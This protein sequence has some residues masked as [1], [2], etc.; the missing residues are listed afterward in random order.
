MMKLDLD[1]LGAKTLLTD[2]RRSPDGALFS[3]PQLS[4]IDNLCITTDLTQWIYHNQRLFMSVFIVLQSPP[5]K[6]RIPSGDVGARAQWEFWTEVQGPSVGV[7][8]QF[9]NLPGAGLWSLLTANT[10]PITYLNKMYTVCNTVTLSQKQKTNNTHTQKNNLSAVI[11]VCFKGQ[12]EYLENQWCK[13]W[14]LRQITTF[15]THLLMWLRCTHVHQ[16]AT[17]FKDRCLRAPS[18]IFLHEL[19]RI[20]IRHRTWQTRWSFFVA[21]S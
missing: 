5:A 21:P 4:Y 3:C 14:T 12:V 20:P 7:R 17:F 6:L 15:R 10:I 19:R 2:W 13:W 1:L 9:C 11:N 8:S 16:M 18:V